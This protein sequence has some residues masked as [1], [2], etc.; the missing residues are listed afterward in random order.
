MG[1]K[2]W[3]YYIPGAGLRGKCPQC[4]QGKSWSNEVFKLSSTKERT[5]LKKKKK[6]KSE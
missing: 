3:V 6:K 5:G 2:C 1:N 4:F